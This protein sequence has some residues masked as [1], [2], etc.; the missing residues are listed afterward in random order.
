MTVAFVLASWRPDAPAGMERAVAAHAAAL[1][2]AGHNA[3]IITA[4]PIAPNDLPH[5]QHH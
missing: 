5:R 3:M 2:E 1:V 4:D